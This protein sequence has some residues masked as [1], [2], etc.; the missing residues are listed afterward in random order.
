[1]K[2]TKKKMGWM[3]G[4][5]L[6][7]LSVGS[8]GAAEAALPKDGFIEI[9]RDGYML[10]GTPPRLVV[11]IQTQRRD[12]NVQCIKYGTPQQ[13]LDERFPGRRVQAVDWQ[14]EIGYGARNVV[15]YYKILPDA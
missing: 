6:A 4:V 8:V 14:L 12:A 3:A 13:L 5:L 2:Q 9:G 1:M 7:C 15:L 11:C 10:V